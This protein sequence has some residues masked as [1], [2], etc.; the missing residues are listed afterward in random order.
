MNALPAA[1]LATV[2]STFGR[3]I[4]ALRRTL[5]WSTYVVAA[6]SIGALGILTELISMTP[7]FDK[8]WPLLVFNFNFN[9]GSAAFLLA[10]VCA[11]VALAAVR[12]EERQRAAWLL[13]P[14]ALFFL[15]QALW[16]IAGS[17]AGGYY[18]GVQQPLS[19]AGHVAS[20][21]LLGII[22]YA[23]LSRCL[24]DVEFVINRAAVFAGVSLV[25][26]GIF[27]LI[28]LLFNKFFSGASRSTSAIVTIG[29]ALAVGIS[30]QYIHRYVDK[31]VDLV[32]FRARHEHERAL[33][34][35]AHEAAFITDADT[36]LNNAVHEVAVNGETDRVSV[37]LRDECGSYTTARATNGAIETVSENDRGILKLRAWHTP[38]ELNDVDTAL[39]GTRAY[40]LTSRGDLVGILVCGAKRDGQ[41]YAPDESEALSM[42][43]RSVGSA[44]DGLRRERREDLKTAIDD[45]RTGMLEI[46]EALRDLNSPRRGASF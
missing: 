28:E 2:S 45:L 30:L 14:L 25:V 36:L 33:R 3:P 46:Q 29:V 13:T 19:I 35:F 41:G 16:G 9:I 31:V 22:S 1:L 26:V 21:I 11:F 5:E 6:L 17:F 10:S 34:E 24:L 18:G 8:F 38:I 32:F 37:L 4:G 7:W 40:P 43:A 44:L 15:V 27:V 39:V 23:I 12:R 42:V 20:F